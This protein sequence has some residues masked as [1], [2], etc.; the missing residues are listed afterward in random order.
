MEQWGPYLYVY[1]IGG[2]V[3]GVGLFVAWKR[4]AVPSKG[5]VILLLAGLGLYAGGHALLQAAGA[6]GPLPETG[7]AR[8]AEGQVGNWVAWLV[9]ALYFVGIVG[10]G[11]YFAR[12]T[13]TSSDFFFG[14]RRFS[15]WLIAVSC[16]ATTVGA[17]SF[18]KYA[19]A[20]FRFGLSSTMSYL[21]DWFWMPLW[22]LVW[23]P[24][25]YYGR[26]QSVP[27]WFERRFGR[28]ARV[29]ATLILLT[30]LV[31]YVGINF[32]TLGKAIHAMTGIHIFPAA[33][34][35]AAATGIYVAVGGQTSVIMT[36]LA[37]GLLLLA[38]GIGLFVFGVFY[39]GGFGPWWES[40]P[41][42]HRMGLAHLNEPAKFHTMGVF[43]QDAMANGVAFYFMNQGIL[44][45]FMATRSVREGRKAMALVVLL[46]MPLA[47]VAVSG[48]GW[49]GRSMVVLG[50]GG[51]DPAT[52]PDNVFVLVSNLLASPVVFGLVMATLT[53][54]LM[55]TAD[56]LLTA[57]SAVFV[58]D[59]WR[60]FLKPVFA[61]GDGDASDLNMAR[62]STVATA[63]IAVV[64]VPI[65]ASFGSIYRAHAA[66]VAA[67]VP[68]MAVAIVV[69]ACWPRF[70]SHAALLTLIGGSVAMVA[71]MI[72]PDLVVPFTQG[73]A[74][75]GEGIKAHTYMR[76]CYGLAV[77]GGLALLG[78]IFLPMLFPTR[79]KETDPLLVAGSER[80]AQAIFKGG[81][82]KEPGAT[83][84]ATVAATEAEVRTVPHTDEVLVALHPDDR[85]ALGADPGDLIHIGEPSWWHGGLRSLH[86]RIDEGDAPE[87]GRVPLPV[88]LLRPSG[89]KD[90]LRV[91]I[92]LEG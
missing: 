33:C 76:A 22:M 8:G 92:T 44:M 72:F 36:D 41:L 9:V 45:R 68:P 73:A 67:I 23:L 74:A 42:A 34:I 32:L 75:G 78:G 46:V 90:G 63:V 2:A 70:R 48:V 37:Q 57:V 89:L 18:I 62:I 59:I 77:S 83:T 15:G 81:T 80:N 65:F 26:I 58:N 52:D 12:Y 20:G 24:I 5:L 40:L 11:A 47:A 49:V 21:N 56:T 60:P 38:V 1:G 53:A 10:L 79:T 61:R 86:A 55:S 17:Y 51:L 3:F 25:I 30:Y 85:K 6:P 82:P 66:F 54:A 39:V 50:K 29:V 4:G 87:A 7:T 69:G 31:G 14:G 19:S 27:E 64:L 16:V 71:S 91:R 88:S 28:A 35:A 84:Y 13:R 43:W